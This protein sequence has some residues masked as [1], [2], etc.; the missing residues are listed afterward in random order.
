V[1]E[2]DECGFNRDGA[3]LLDDNQNVHVCDET[4][5]C[6]DPD[7]VGDLVRYPR[8]SCAD[9]GES[10]ARLTALNNAGVPVY[11]VGVLGAAD[12]DDAMNRLAVAG[13]RP[14][15]G[16]RAYYDVSSLSELTSTVRSIGVDLTQTCEIELLERPLYANELNVYF[17]ALLVPSDPGDGWTLEED[18]VTL[19]GD[20]C[21]QVKGGEVEQVRLVSGCQTVVK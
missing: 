12:F 8:A 15:D 1:C 17:D 7:Q 4:L 10:E 13:G 21:D 2:A 14:R 6:C 18:L 9:I 5:N 20:A 3:V 16:Q 11:V 19:H